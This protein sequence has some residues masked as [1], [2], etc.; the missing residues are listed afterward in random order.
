MKLQSP[1]PPDKPVLDL[2]TFQQLLAAAY[3]MQQSRPLVKEA[4]S[5]SPPT[6]PDEASHQK[7]HSIPPAS[8]DDSQRDLEMNT[9]RPDLVAEI[10]ESEAFK[11]QHSKATQVMRVRAVRRTVVGSRNKMLRRQI[12]QSNKLFWRVATALAMPAV[13]GVLL[14]APIDRLSPLPDGLVLPPELLQQPVPFRKA[15][16][17]ATP[18][19]QTGVGR[20]A[21]LTEPRV[22]ATPGA[23]EQVVADQPIADELIADEPIADELIPDKPMERD[24]NPASAGKAVIHSAY[25]SEADVV[26]QNTVVRYGPQSPAVR[27]QAQKP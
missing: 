9:Q 27:P 14:A 8:L 20:K 22:M 2:Q 16:P 17:M 18:P 5:D 6:L 7:F 23:N 21:A 19:A 3:T 15:Q 25:E 13:L 12:D 11:P 1:N 4:T 10:L 26:A 24:A